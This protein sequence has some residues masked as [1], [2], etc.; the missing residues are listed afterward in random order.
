VL[1]VLLAIV[2]L[3]AGGGGLVALRRRSDHG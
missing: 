2:S 1:F 3:A